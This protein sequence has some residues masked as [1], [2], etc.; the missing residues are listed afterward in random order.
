MR[1]DSSDLSAQWIGSIYPSREI[2]A[3]RMDYPYTQ[4]KAWRSFQVR[5]V[6]DRSPS[7]R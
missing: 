7:Q 4:K 6:D 2:L 5:A 3:K 1:Y